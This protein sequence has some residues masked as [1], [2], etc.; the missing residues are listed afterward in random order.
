MHLKTL[1]FPLL[2]IAFTSI[3]ARET[4][5]LSVLVL[6]NYNHFI[7]SDEI[8]SKISSDKTLFLTGSI[9]DSN[10]SIQ[11]TIPYI[12]KYS[13][14]GDLIWEKSF[15]SLASYVAQDIYETE[16]KEL[17]LILN[18]TD[19]SNVKILKL[20][21]LQ[22]SLWCKT[23]DW[24]HSDIGLEFLETQDNNILI[25]GKTRSIS[26][27]S[28]TLFKLSISEEGDSL[29]NQT[30]PII[31]DMNQYCLSDTNIIQVGTIRKSFTKHGIT[32]SQMDISFSLNNSD[33]AYFSYGETYSD[34]WPF[35]EYGFN[36]YP[37][38]DT[39]FIIIGCNG[40]YSSDRGL[41][42]L[43]EINQ[44][45][46]SIYN[47]CKGIS[48]SSNTE[49]YTQS[50]KTS[51][52]N[53]F[54]AVAKATNCIAANNAL[55][56]LE[57]RDKEFKSIWTQEFEFKGTDYS[58]KVIEAAIDTLILIGTSINSKEGISFIRIVDK[59]N[60]QVSNLNTT[61]S[62]SLNS[63]QIEY[64]NKSKTLRINQSISENRTSTFS[65][66]NIKGQNVISKKISGSS[67]EL[68]IN[69]K[70]LSAGNYFVFISNKDEIFK[71]K[72]II[73]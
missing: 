14:K 67:R 39:S 68:F 27:S 3:S 62:K 26:T 55:L 25:L 52:G 15:S 35:H 73:K 9:T 43:L 4:T 30:L 63:F 41:P 71:G 56:V 60:Q 2:I 36:I 11:T 65:L 20:N 59:S 42:L 70:D 72:I 29:A 61:I 51:D 32:S 54:G 28:Y 1:I 6:N 38:T 48:T 49:Y 57:K 66:Y 8:R 19:K 58:Y 21:S 10:N 17:Y 31:P 37:K 53:I 7:L 46:K 18:K 24:S 13:I 33:S 44:N 5:D 16:Q 22:D 40:G 64:M 45:G 69:L 34:F 47:D 12:G 23:I 50:F